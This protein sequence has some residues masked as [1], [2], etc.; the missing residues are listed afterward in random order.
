MDALNCRKLKNEAKQALKNASPTPQ[1]LVLLYAV[2]SGAALLILSVIRLILERQIANTTGLSGLGTRSVLSTVS[3][4]AQ[5]AVNLALPFW[6][7]GFTA[8][9]LRFAR[10]ESAAPQVLLTGF[11]CFGPVIRLLLLKG[12]IYFLPAFLCFYPAVMLFFLTPFAAP[13]TDTL[14]PLISEGAD[15]NTV[16]QNEAVLAAMEKAALPMELVFGAVYLVVCLPI[17]Y[18]IRFADLALMDAPENGALAALRRSLRLTRR[19]WKPLVRLDLH[20]LW[21]YVLSGG[22]L[23]AAYGD[24]LL[25]RL[26]IPLPLNADT[27]AFLFYAVHLLLDVALSYFAKNTVETTYAMCYDA[28]DGAPEDVPPAP[29]NLPWNT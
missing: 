7:M 5:G 27:A 10:R 4:V 8:A 26:G 16:L 6:T 14:L 28:L 12:L 2:V 17:F 22:I 25:S 18:R 19:R 20:F 3:A 1:K 15:V 13:L 11:R 23:A 29:K 24:V 9:V 21:Y